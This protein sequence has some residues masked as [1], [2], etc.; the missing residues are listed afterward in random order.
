ML[1]IVGFWL[2]TVISNKDRK[3]G[4]DIQRDTCVFNRCSH[5]PLNPKG[6][7]ILDAPTLKASGSFHPPPKRKLQRG[8][9]VL[10]HFQWNWGSGT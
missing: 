6:S 3:A 5:K 7:S 4:S 8:D 1:D 2:P 10:L 9:P